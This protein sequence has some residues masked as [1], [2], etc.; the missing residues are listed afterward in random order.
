MQPRPGITMKGIFLYLPLKYIYGPLALSFFLPVFKD[1]S[2][3]V[4]SNQLSKNCECKHHFHPVISPVKSHPEIRL[5]VNICENL[6]SI[7]QSFLLARKSYNQFLTKEFKDFNLI[8]YFLCFFTQLKDLHSNLRTFKDFKDRYE[9]CEM[10]KSW[11][12][13]P[14]LHKTFAIKQTK[15]F[16][17]FCCIEAF[18]CLWPCL[19]FKHVCINWLSSNK[20]V[21]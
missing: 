9:P 21:A 16:S 15:I 13:V 19:R 14:N 4:E 12:N 6:A 17:V 18:G 8:K 7:N 20:F 10:N 1:F 11:V 3:T 5:F 2:K